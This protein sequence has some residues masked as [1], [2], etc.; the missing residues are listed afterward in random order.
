MC[1]HIR[2][3]PGEDVGKG[4]GGVSTSQGTPKI[5]SKPPETRRKTWNRFSLTASE[6][7]KSA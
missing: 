1:M 4:Q 7:T 6:G 5:A 2:R 3:V